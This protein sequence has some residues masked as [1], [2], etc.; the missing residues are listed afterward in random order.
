M[1]EMTE[2]DDTSNSKPG[3][4]PAKLQAV[5]PKPVKS[6]AP[7]QESCFQL[8]LRI[9]HDEM[10]EWPPERMATFFEAVS[11]VMGAKANASISLRPQVESGLGAE[12]R[13]LESRLST[14]LQEQASILADAQRSANVT[15]E[16]MRT[17]LASARERSFDSAG[18]RKSVHHIGDSL[19]SVE[20]RIR[21]IEQTVDGVRRH[22]AT[23]H[24]SIAEDFKT[25]E[26]NLT[27]H[28]N[29]IQSARTAMSQT[30]DLVERV[31]EALEVLQTS[32][33]RADDSA[34]AT[35]N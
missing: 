12:L 19:D 32:T 30:D 2:L 10:S 1:P 21:R 4:R 26:D 17:E 35:V 15:L 20:E 23:L 24:E 14:R 11:V 22:V 27:N 29:A 25:F 34:S 9:R 6:L 8:N 16:T 13:N 33:L 31:V 7:D 3:V 5:A 18:A 28:T